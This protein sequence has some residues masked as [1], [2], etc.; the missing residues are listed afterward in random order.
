VLRIKAAAFGWFCAAGFQAACPFIVVSP[1]TKGG[2]ITHTYAAHAPVVN[3]FERN[4]GLPPLTAQ[5]G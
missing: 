1:F 3:I 2:R 4:R 5:P